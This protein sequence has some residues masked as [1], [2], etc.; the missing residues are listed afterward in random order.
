MWHPAAVTF[1]TGGYT[2]IG[3]VVC[4]D[5]GEAYINDLRLFKTANATV[6]NE[7]NN[8]PKKITSSTLRIDDSFITQNDAVTINSIV[9]QLDNKQYIRVFKDGAEITDLNQ[10]ISTGVQLRLMDGPSVYDRVDIAL[11]G[12]INGDGVC[13]KKDAAIVTDS[14][15]NR[16]TLTKLQTK[17]LDYDK[18]GTG[19]INDA[20]LLVAKINSK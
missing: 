19:D 7:Q 14:L 4:D 3:F 2:K 13:D 6:R 10:K 15:I 18:N 17:A 8:F 5:G 11:M 16:V 20:V 1:N 9:S 12:D